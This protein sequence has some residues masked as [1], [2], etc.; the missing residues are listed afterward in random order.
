MNLPNQNQINAGT[1]HLISAIGGAAL[2]FGVS[3]V[4]IDK[5]NI[6]VNSLSGIMSNLVILVGLLTPI[7]AGY[8]A[9][10]SASPASQAASL[11]K[12][13]AIV[14]TTPEIAQATPD[15]PNVVSQD[16]VKVVMK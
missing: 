10:R 12:Q 9:S 15:S 5:I 1:R 11:E 2:M 4:S 3:S 14:V 13:G 7:I 6:L 8:Y 16:E